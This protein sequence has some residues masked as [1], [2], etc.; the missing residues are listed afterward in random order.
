MTSVLPAPPFTVPSSED[1]TPLPAVAALAPLGRLI[2]GQACR[3]PL[4]AVQVIL[5][6]FSEVSMYRV[7]PFWLTSTVPSPDTLLALTV[8]LEVAAPALLAA[9]GEL[10]PGELALGELALG[11]LELLAPPAA[12]P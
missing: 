6:P 4:L 9:L 5:P 3:Q 7:W 8:T 12:E 11:A 1:F 10:A 2:S